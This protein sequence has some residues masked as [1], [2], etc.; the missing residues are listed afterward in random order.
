MSYL[1]HCRCIV[2]ISCGLCNH[3][4]AWRVVLF[5]KNCFLASAYGQYFLFLTLSFS[6]YSNWVSPLLIVFCLK[7]FEKLITYSFSTWVLQWLL[8]LQ[9]FLRHLWCLFSTL[10]YITLSLPPLS[11][12]PVSLPS[13]FLSS[14][15][16]CWRADA[17]LPVKKVSITCNF[18][19]HHLSKLDVCTDHWMSLM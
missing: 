17:T 19:C 16:L 2:I 10:P 15:D 1:N 9:N 18:N 3:S 14:F 7:W 4:I 13:P 5:I 8:W 11:L 6:A 12:H